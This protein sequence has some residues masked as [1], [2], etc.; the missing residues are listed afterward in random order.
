MLAFR[1]LDCWVSAVAAFDQFQLSPC[2]AGQMISA[3]VAPFIFEAYYREE[4]VRTTF[5]KV[6]VDYSYCLR[7][8]LS[9]D[10]VLRFTFAWTLP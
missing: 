2:R 3:K 8:I 9:F 1:H 10:I 7:N 5:T 4:F 6:I